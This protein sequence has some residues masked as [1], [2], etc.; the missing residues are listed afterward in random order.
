LGDE[1]LV[2]YNS[3]NIYLFD[4]NDEKEKKI[5]EIIEEKEDLVEGEV[6]KGLKNTYKGHRNVKT[7]KEVN[8]YGPNCEYV[9]SGVNK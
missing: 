2:T 3:D 7:V 9:I 5:E 8:F 4:I 6:L 1:F